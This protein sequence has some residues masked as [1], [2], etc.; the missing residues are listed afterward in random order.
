MGEICRKDSLARN[1]QKY[2]I[3][4]AQLGISVKKIC[5]TLQPPPGW[6]E[7]TRRSITLFLGR[8]YCQ[9]STTPSATTF[10]S[11]NSDGDIKPSSSSLTRVLWETGELAIHVQLCSQLCGS[12][13]MYV[14]MRVMNSSLQHIFGSL[15]W[16]HPQGP[17]RS[18]SGLHRQGTMYEQLT[19]SECL[20]EV[21]FLGDSDLACGPGSSI[22]ISYV[23][24]SFHDNHLVPPTLI[25]FILLREVGQWHDLK[26]IHP[27]H[28][29]MSI[30]PSSCDD[31]VLFSP[32]YW[33]DSNVTWGSTSWWPP[34]ILWGY[35]ST[36]MGWWVAE[37]SISQYVHGMHY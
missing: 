35:S 11:W 6:V 17:K 8:G 32:S 14:L 12:P 19:L 5:L 27:V 28:C 22:V 26:Q 13:N 37:L 33:M 10:E 24:T 2:V 15:N 31:Y 4:N 1:I 7:F 25:G 29:P 9:G 30:P 18:S 3:T 21:S 20:I 36:K 16:W 23:T 34:A